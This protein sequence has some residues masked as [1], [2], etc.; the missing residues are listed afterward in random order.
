MSPTLDANLNTQFS[1]GKLFV[2]LEGKEPQGECFADE[3][4]R[5]AILLKQSEARLVYLNG[6]SST[7]TGSSADLLDDDFAWLADAAV[8]REFRL[9]W[10]SLGH[11]RCKCS[12]L[13]MA[14][15][16]SLLDQG[17]PEIALWRARC[18][19]LQISMI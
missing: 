5:I 3:S 6:C 1:G 2:F 18:E 10:Q 14:F 7:T 8:Q 4:N 15:Y 17:S 13:A 12:K 9:L 11:F 16:M 19:L